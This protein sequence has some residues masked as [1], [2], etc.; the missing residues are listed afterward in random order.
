MP[1]TVKAKAANNIKYLRFNEKAMIDLKNFNMELFFLFK[2]LVRY[3]LKL[4]L[5]R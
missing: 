5:S 1:A 2:N 3:K 4:H